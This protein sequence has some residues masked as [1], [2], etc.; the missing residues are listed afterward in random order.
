[1]SGAMTGSTLAT[2]LYGGI[3]D[4]GLPSGTRQ[5]CFQKTQPVFIGT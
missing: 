5:L 4:I 1:M 2:A 3:V